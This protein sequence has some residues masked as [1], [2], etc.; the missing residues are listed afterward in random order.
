MGKGR[1]GRS[2]VVKARADML[3]GEAAVQ[4]SAAVLVGG[5]RVGQG[6]WE[7]ATS[8]VFVR[9]CQ[10]ILCQTLSGGAV[11]RAAGGHGPLDG[12]R[13]R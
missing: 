6:R 13:R 7:G 11:G 9:L 4:V 12:E 10:T 3:A 2:G 5:G 1:F 8:S